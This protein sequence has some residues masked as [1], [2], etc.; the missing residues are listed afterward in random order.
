MLGALV[1]KYFKPREYNR[2]HN[3]VVTQV[4]KELDLIKVISR[5]RMLVLATLGTLTIHQRSIVCKM[6]RFVIL[7]DS[8]GSSSENRKNP[9]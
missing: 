3:R 8:D 1:K 4:S 7:S 2:V 9:A 5:L 6:G